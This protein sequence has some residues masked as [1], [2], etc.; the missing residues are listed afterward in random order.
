VS[1]RVLPGFRLSLG[2]T[3]LW[4]GLIVVLPLS[5]L[6][7]RAFGL[8]WS[9]LWRIWSTPRVLSALELSFGVAAAAAAVNLVMGLLVA[10]VLVR[11]RFPGRRFVDALVDLPFALPTAVAGIALTSLYASSGWL[12]GPLHDWFGVDVAFTRLGIGIALIFVTLPF[13]VR[14]VQPV[15][16]GVPFEVEEAAS[17]LGASRWQVF[18]RVILPELVPA[19]ATGFALAMARGVGEYGSVVFISGNLPNKT[20]ILPQVIV[21]KLDQF[22]FADATAIA[23]LMLLVS[24]ALLLTINLLQ[25]WA[26]R[27]AAA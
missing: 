3:L 24:F 16:E 6:A 11:Y 14:T 19:L 8:S 5:A 20:E 2:I 17:S 4:L 22:K 9:D 15:L 10:W 13:V 1:T 21:G 25:R 23:M 7:A 26:Q 12:G 27:R 18:R